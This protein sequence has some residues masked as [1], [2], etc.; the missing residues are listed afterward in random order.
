MKSQPPS[1]QGLFKVWIVAPALLFAACALMALSAQGQRIS[2]IP[3]GAVWEY[4]DT[5]LDPGSAWRAPAFDASA[6]ASGPAQLGFGDGDE[7]TVLNSGT[8]QGRLITAYFRHRFVLA[9]AGGISNLTA[10]LVYDDGAV[11]Y[12]NGVEAF[13]VG[14][15]PGPVSYSTLASTTVSD[16][17]LYTASLNPALLVRGTNVVAVEVHQVNSLSTD[18]SFDFALTAQPAPSGPGSLDLTF[19]P[20]RGGQV[21][22]PA[23]S[24]GEVVA[25]ARQ[26]DGNLL[27]GGQFSGYN[28][29]L[30]RH[31]A[32][33]LPTGALDER[34]NPGLGVDG[35][36]Y[37]V[38]LQPNGQVLVGGSFS[39]FDTQAC[40][41]LVRLN[42]DG[43]LDAAFRPVLASYNA[44]G[45]VRAIVIQTNGKIL[46][47]GSFCQVDGVARTNVA[48][49]NPDGSLDAGF[50]PASGAPDWYQGVVNL[51]V[52]ADGKVL[53]GGRF[54]GE[55][56]LLCRLN[57]DGSLDSSFATDLT[58]YELVQ[59]A[60]RSDGKIYAAGPFD[61]G[62]PG[63]YYSRLALVNPDGSIDSSFAV[64]F[65]NDGFYCFT[66]LAVQPDDRLLVAG[67]FQSVNGVPRYRIAR[68]SPDG[69]LDESFDPGDC[70]RD[71]SPA[72]GFNSMVLEPDGHIWLGGSLPLT[73]GSEASLVRLLPSGRLDNDFYAAAGDL[74]LPGHD[75]TIQALTTL[76]DGRVYVGGSFA[77]YNNQPRANVARILPDGSLDTSFRPTWTNHF[78]VG[79]LALQPD[80][81]LLAGGSGEL[82]RFNPDG[83]LDPGFM[84]HLHE[85]LGMRLRCLALQAD[86]KIVLGGEFADGLARLNADGSLDDTFNP[87]YL[88]AYD[89]DAVCALA[90]QP[91]GKILFGGNGAIGFQ[92]LHP[93]GSVDSTFN[94]AGQSGFAIHKIL[95]QPDGAILIAGQPCLWLGEEMICLVRLHPDGRVD[96]SFN[97]PVGQYV[98]AVAVAPDG[99][100][101]AAMH[102][103]SGGQPTRICRLDPH[104]TVDPAFHARLGPASGQPGVSASLIQADGQVLIGGS[105][106]S[107]NGV[108]VDGLARLNN[109]LA[110]AAPF[111]Q[112]VFT[113][114]GGIRLVALPSVSVNVYAIEDQPPAGWAV[115]TISHGGVFDSRT[116]KV[117]FGPF[118][119]HE[120]RTLTY[121][122][123][124]PIWGTHCALGVFCFSGQASADGINSPIA[125]DQCQVLAGCFPA[126]L[127]PA[128]Q[129][130]SIGELTAYGAAWRRG[131]NW[132][133]HAHG[134]PIDYVTRA[135]FLWR[136]GECYQVISSVTNEPLWWARCES[137]SPLLP[138]QRRAKSL[139]W[140]ERRTPAFFVP[141][142]PLTVTLAA[143]PAASTAGYAVEDKPPAGWV[144]S[145]VSSGGQFDAQNGN[146][147]WGPFLDNISRTLTYRATPPPTARGPA[148]FV[149]MSSSDGLSAR[150]N[151]CGELGESCRLRVEGEPISGQ[152]HFTFN[153]R[154]G[155]SFVLEISN[156]L[157]IWTPWTTVSNAQGTLSFTSRVRPDTPQQFFRARPAE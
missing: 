50:V 53:V 17:A 18:L 150:I 154:T 11:V 71:W 67:W 119:D 3:A 40:S 137:G 133:C 33:L 78:E 1:A 7:S 145:D 63:W 70:L 22:G 15:P 131:S 48:R 31:I 152:F 130:I 129:R 128:D 37:A 92:R 123:Q 97:A 114:N 44:P 135:A 93:D 45:V 124:G 132:L 55:R 2:L 26:P 104:G 52:L 100:I 14:M 103:I 16:N 151:G 65:A 4:L 77:S 80:A 49:L 116:G 105:F 57:P 56:K 42:P 149:G 58:G 76:T 120:P 82:V 101:L 122:A 146:V 6:W 74:N 157:M 59:F 69:R 86:G 138:D 102:Q 94:F 107:V 143:A 127:D 88:P 25:L 38:A 34:F 9:G 51:A 13:R 117:K 66:A 62:R 79:L 5:G 32:R 136:G 91:D 110:A 68:L 12:F 27:V 125:G 81:K 140:T 139:G 30:R 36:V 43:S 90:V 23:S 115:S 60:V 39:V 121:H 113:T 61:L 10:S 84:G 41:S 95:V 156:D 126:D 108:P 96:E 109:H 112:R 83:S 111:V 134:I 29:R 148:S 20:T 155:A 73:N 35:H 21:I 28:G 141:G 89:G 144:V 99:Y 24:S 46:V 47:G 87:P 8:P 153:G 54:L 106:T 142:E 85:S 147:K 118:F 64:D 98:G 19:D 75:V 72:S